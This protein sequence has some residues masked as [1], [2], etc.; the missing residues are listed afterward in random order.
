MST[1]KAVR[2]HAYGGPEVLSID[3]VNRPQPQD[4]EVLLRVIATS[5]NP[6]DYKIRSGT[7]GKQED[8]PVALGRDVSGVVE[9]CGT[10]AH[11]L[12]KGDPIYA[13]LGNDRGAHAE[14]V[15]VKATEMAAKPNGLDHTTAASVPLS[16]LT[17]W[18]ALFDHGRL[19]PGQRVLIHGGAGGVGHFAVQFAKAKGAWVA[20]TVSRDDLDFAHS[21][22]ADQVVDYKNERF[23]DV[24]EPVDLVIDLVAGETQDRS[25]AV[26]KTGG[27]IVSTLSKPDDEEAREHQVQGI[28]FMAGPNGAQLLEIGRLISE[29]KVR[30]HVDAVF[31]L[32]DVA[33][34]EDQLENE[35]VRGKIVLQ[36]S[37]LR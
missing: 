28:Y 14:F 37:P 6:V 13:M 3:D 12:K 5:V 10:R 18:Q 35:H 32:E 27:T 20:T 22:G 17:A 25:W 29:G 8:L 26:V 1:M 34:A 36:V 24:V 16:G 31:N 21:L 23:E 33:K 30:P 19:S 7:Y 4:D 2:I 9:L 11:S 15:I